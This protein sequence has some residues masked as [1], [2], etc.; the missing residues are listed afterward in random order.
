MH[1]WHKRYF[2]TSGPNIRAEH[3]TLSRSALVEVCRQ[4]V[5]HDRYFTIWAPRQTG[6]STYF[7]FLA[8]VLEA[9]GYK[10]AFVNFENFSN[11]TLESFLFE[12]HENLQNSWGMSFELL[13][14]EATFTT[15][16]SIK[17]Q[18]FV[19]IIDEVEGINPSF[20]GTVLHSIR[21]VYHTR[22]NHALKSVILVGVSN[23]VGVVQDNASPF[24]I[25][26]N[27]N[28]PYFTDAETRE[29]LAQHEDETG[30]HFEESVKQKI[31]AITA[32]QPGLVNGFAWKLTQEFHEKKVIEFD[33]YLKVEYWYLHESIDKNVS[34]IINKGKKH[35]Q[36]IEKLLFTDYTELFQVNREHIR[37]L[38]ANGL[39][40]KGEDG[41]VVFHVPLYKKALQTAF[42]PYINGERKYIGGNIEIDDYFIK[43]EQEN[44]AKGDKLRLD[45][46]I[47][48]YKEYATKRGFRHF[49]EKDEKGN[50]LGLRESALVYS[51][52]TYISAFLEVVGGKSYLEA[53]A[54][55]GRT[56]LLVNV[57]GHEYVFE[58]KVYANIT[59]FN[60]GKGQ[61]AYY[62]KS[63]GLQTGIYLVFVENTIT[64]SKVLEA[65]E[66]IEGIEIVTHLI[67]YDMETSF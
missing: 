33:D 55:L 9:E 62:L 18:K 25:S 22:Q 16:S 44:S 51:F 19:L 67:W 38:S 53:H 7:R 32:N 21:N 20:F 42:Y 4:M 17:D 13:S 29:L 43:N 8:E 23:I 40:K 27:L 41:N 24:N 14:L 39:I 5:H 11:A 61:L 35:R 6:K 50:F 30:Q 52:E 15:I 46:I 64:H 37:E 56:D 58:A 60:R 1:F 3:Y 31:I 45:K 36:F 12:F 10:V 49:R 2:N 28:V 66:T 48:K 63:L 65:V 57:Q 34:N 47:E 59:Q 54:G 26:D